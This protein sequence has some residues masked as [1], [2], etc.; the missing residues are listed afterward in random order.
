[1]KQWTAIILALILAVSLFAGCTDSSGST[2]RRRADRRDDAKEEF[3]IPGTWYVK[4]INGKKPFDQFKEYIQDFVDEEYDGDLDSYLEDHSFS[5]DDLNNPYTMTLN[6][7]GTGTLTHNIW[8]ETVPIT[9]VLDGDTVTLS[10]EEE[11]QTE[12]LTVRDNTLI[13]MDDLYS[14]ELVETVFAKENTRS[15]G[16]DD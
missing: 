14:D 3:T 1:M 8:K 2:G 9:W 10:G 5:E 7:D 15:R 13:L 11:G 4:S 12:T 6:E 16:V